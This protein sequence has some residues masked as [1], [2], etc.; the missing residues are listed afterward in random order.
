[1]RR[2]SEALRSGQ[3][4]A[5]GTQRDVALLSCLSSLS[6]SE[7]SAAGL[8]WPERPSLREGA[9]VGQPGTS[10][11]PR[12][13]QGHEEHQ[14]TAASGHAEGTQSPWHS[15]NV[16]TLEGIQA[17]GC[18]TCQSP[19]SP[20]SHSPSCKG[21]EAE[22]CPGTTLLPAHG[23]FPHSFPLAPAPI[24]PVPP[25][26]PEPVNEQRHEDDEEEDDNGREANEPR[27]QYLGACACMARGR[28]GKRWGWGQLQG[29][30]ILQGM[31]PP[32]MRQDP[33]L[34]G[35]DIG[36]QSLFPFPTVPF[37]SR[38]PPPTQLTC[39]QHSWEHWGSRWVSPD[40]SAL[41]PKV[42]VGSDWPHYKGLP[43]ADLMP[44][45]GLATSP[46]TPGH[47]WYRGSW[48]HLPACP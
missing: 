40:L 20:G 11:A 30:S 8:T 25:E 36:R 38:K 6:S 47:R 31:G 44:G 39:P 17:P 19:G 43:G 18:G 42:T 26:I 5:G 13:C 12:P 27:L 28:E 45:G 9:N 41:P 7:F 24:Q 16:A 46:G 34:M 2:P 4:G 21:R 22:H 29:S 37:I 48:R 1:M 33:P 23:N 32:S 3:R 10:P 14:G 15:Q 35:W